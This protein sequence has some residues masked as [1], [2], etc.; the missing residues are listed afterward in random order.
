MGDYWQHWLDM[1]KAIAN[2]PKIF[3][4]NWFRTD[5]Q[6]N[7]IWPGFS[8]NL[9]VVE[10]ILKRCFD[11]VGARETEIGYLPNVEDINLDGVDVDRET[12]ASLLSPW[13]GTSGGKRPSRSAP[14][15]PSSATSSPDAGEGAGGS[16]GP[17]AG[18]RTTA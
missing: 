8:E 3:N 5:D 11:E 6:G 2:P 12:L 1:E 7:F 16:G 13:T 18:L 4:V 14:S 9:R 17:P 10:W 15:M